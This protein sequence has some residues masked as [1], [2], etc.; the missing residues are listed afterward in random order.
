M[1]HSSCLCHRCIPNEE[2]SNTTPSVVTFLPEGEVAVG[3]Q[4]KKSAARHP[5]TTY[6]STKRL[7]G[8]KFDDPVVQAEQARLPYEVR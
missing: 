5:G 1:T 6:S 4:A 2:G 8:R 7:I 3:S